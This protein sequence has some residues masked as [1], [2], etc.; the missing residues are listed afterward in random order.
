ML[1]TDK[2]CIFLGHP[3]KRPCFLKCALSYVCIT[4]LPVVPAL[5]MPAVEDFCLPTCPLHQVYN[6][7][8]RKP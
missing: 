5:E 6:L 3:L 2:N 7:Y 1:A 8:F 4:I